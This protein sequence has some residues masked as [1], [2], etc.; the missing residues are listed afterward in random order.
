MAR[1]QQAAAT[2]PYHEVYEIGQGFIKVRTTET[3]K[4]EFMDDPEL[5][6]PLSDL[7]ASDYALVFQYNNKRERSY[8]DTVIFCNQVCSLNA[9]EK[10]FSALHMADGTFL[11]LNVTF[12]DLLQAVLEA[13]KR[14]AVL[15]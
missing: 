7:L 3:A 1:Q 14:K 11:Y 15:F 2:P 6:D 5:E 4:K 9:G 10:G 12:D 8:I 13:E